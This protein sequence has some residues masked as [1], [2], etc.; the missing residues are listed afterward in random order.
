MDHHSPLAQETHRG[1]RLADPLPPR[2]FFPPS[3]DSS[4][5]SLCAQTSETHGS[6]VLCATQGGGGPPNGSFDDWAIALCDARWNWYDRETSPVL[7]STGISS[8]SRWGVGGQRPECG[9]HTF[10]RRR[11]EAGPHGA[12]AG[13]VGRVDPVR[14][15][16]R[17][18]SSRE[19]C[20]RGVSPA[21]AVAVAA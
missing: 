19:C 1:R 14:R 20:I 18:Y 8:Q 15:C 12:L 4:H 11:F 3:S 16:R 17:R 6:S 2:V 5:F 10:P 13:R 7:S 21:A 9:D